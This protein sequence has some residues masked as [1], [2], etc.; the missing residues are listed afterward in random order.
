VAI[1]GP[2]VAGA[3]GVIPLIPLLDQQKSVDYLMGIA[4][5]MEPDTDRAELRKFFASVLGLELTEELK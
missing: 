1:S 3:I 2:E 4:H 5:R